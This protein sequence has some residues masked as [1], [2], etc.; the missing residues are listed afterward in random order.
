MQKLLCPADG[1]DVTALNC[2]EICLLE[3]RLYYELHTYRH[4]AGRDKMSFYYAVFR[5]QNFIC[6]NNVHLQNV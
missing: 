1:A 2:I 5:L 4:L 3:A 6:H